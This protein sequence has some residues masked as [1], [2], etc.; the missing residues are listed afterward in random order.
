MPY[1]NTYK[2]MNALPVY[3]WKHLAVFIHLTYVGI[4]I[5]G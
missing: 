3:F 4:M 5:H 1:G 2:G